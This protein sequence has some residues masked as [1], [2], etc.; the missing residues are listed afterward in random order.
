MLPILVAATVGLGAACCSPYIAAHPV[1][2]ASPVGVSGQR[3]QTW[4]VVAEYL[5]MN[6]VS[7]A[8]LFSWLCTKH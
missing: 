5:Q 8:V 2:Q 1:R 6:L 3:A 7:F 4:L